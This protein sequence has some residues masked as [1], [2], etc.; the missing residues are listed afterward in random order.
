VSRWLNR[1]RQRAGDG[2]GGFTLIEIM[3]A[4]TLVAIAAGGSIPLLI[5]GMK[6]ANNSKLQTQAKNL[7]QQRFESM[8]DLPFHVDRQNGPFVD[9]LDVYYTNVSGTVASHDRAGEHEDGSYA[10]TRTSPA[11]SGPS[12]KVSVSSIPDFDSFTQTIYTQ[13]LTVTGTALPA[14]NFPTYDSQ[15]EGKDQP[16]SLMV[17]VT[18]VTTWKDHGTS[19]SYTSYSRIADSRGLTSTLTTQGSASF[20][21]VTSAGA[22][23]NALT[24][25]VAS[26]DASGSQSTG[27]VAAADVRTLEAHDSTGQDYEGATRVFTSPSG[28]T[29][30]NG[31][32]PLAA[33]AAGGSSCGWVGSGQTDVANVTASTAQANGGVP[34]VPSNVDTNSPP[35]NQAT[36]QIK[37]T[38]SGPCGLFGFSN[39]STTYDPNLLLTDTTRPLVQIRD[40]SGNSV[41]VKGS[42][43]VNATSSTANPHTASSG[44]NTSS[45]DTLRLFPNAAFTGGKGILKVTLS[46]AS[47]SCLSSVTAG[48]ATQSAAGSWTV[49]I[50]Y[51]KASDT[52]GNGG[53]FD[54][55]QYTWNS[56]TGSG[57][58]DPLASIDP[59]S[60]VV[61]QNGS[62]ILHLSDYIS[63]WSTERKIVEDQNSGVHQLNGI[64]SVATTPVRAGDILSGVGLQLGNLSCV[65]DDNR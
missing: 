15:T 29:S 6:A 60:I 39:Q 54:L 4:I 51:W 23:G 27:S 10:A 49:N 31:P 24:V 20:L 3:V 61:Y 16:P 42:A 41:A 56:A 62:T 25:D 44:A 35:T 38:G 64:V 52:S 17:G 36:A 53:W 9:L 28:T 2:Q 5:V 50:S 7:A 55:P 34:W 13:F 37:S 63:S 43:W 45:A 11:P 58:A 12:Y 33:W 21:R 40:D 32:F 57:S 26:A 8:R 48:V 22:A 59:A 30:D 18:V 65:A 46:Q 14:S 1:A 47:M 19:H